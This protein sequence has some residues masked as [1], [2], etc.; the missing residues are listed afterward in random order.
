VKAA[1]KRPAR[2]S[3]RKPTAKR[4]ARRSSRKPTAPA[5]TGLFAAPGAELGLPF[6]APELLLSRHDSALAIQAERA[7]REWLGSGW[8]PACAFTVVQDHEQE[9]RPLPRFVSAGTEAF[10]NAALTFAGV[11][12]VVA[13]WHWLA[14]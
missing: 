7:R 14:H 1:A 8:R 5:A 4:P 2:R 3:S 13:A 12:A 6:T 9:L 10:R 11:A